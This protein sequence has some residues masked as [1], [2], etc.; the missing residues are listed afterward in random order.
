MSLELQDKTILIT[1]AGRGIG[2][3]TV[4]AATEAGATVIA[5]ARTQS[6]LDEVKRLCPERI[7]TWAMDVEDSAFYRRIEA[8][9]KLDGLFNNAGTNHPQGLLDVTEEVL[10]TMLNLNVRS[11][12]LVARSA[13]RV[14]RK[15][16]S[17]VIVNMSSQLGH[18]G[19]AG[20]TVYCA[21]KHAV[22]GMT[23]AMAVEMAPL[24][25]RINSIAPTFVETPLTKPMFEDAEFQTSVLNR[26]PMGRVGQVEEVASAVIFLLSSRSS[27]MTG[28]SLILDGGWNAH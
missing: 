5:V 21:T 17:G 3:A 28:S 26:I 24:G 7:E 10:D 8:L 6:D 25:L 23:K 15:Q 9:K 14:M 11:T 1:G 18:V 19:C 16:K 4:Q 20:R 2:R 22:E 13:A 12:F 27:L